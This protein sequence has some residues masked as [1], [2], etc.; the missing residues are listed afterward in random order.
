MNFI[1]CTIIFMSIIFAVSTANADKDEKKA[2]GWGPKKDEIRMNGEW[3][4]KEDWS[5][6]GKGLRTGTITV[7]KNNQKIMLTNIRSGLVFRGVMLDEKRF[8]AEATG[9]MDNYNIQGIF[10]SSFKATYTMKVR[11]KT[12]LGELE[13]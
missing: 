12:V 7:Q 5:E 11:G 8:Q 1:K 13:R 9:T 4:Y 3:D 10:L 6:L 2:G